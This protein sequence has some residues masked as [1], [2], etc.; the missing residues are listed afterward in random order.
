MSYEYNYSVRPI[1]GRLIAESKHVQSPHQIAVKRVV[2]CKLYETCSFCTLFIY[3]KTVMF[4]LCG[5]G[6]SRTMQV[7]V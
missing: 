2:W 5:P 3:R 6:A 4:G 7:Q 1:Y